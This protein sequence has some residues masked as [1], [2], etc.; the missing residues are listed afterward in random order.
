GSRVSSVDTVIAPQPLGSKSPPD[1]VL[2]AK[3][4][5]GPM[6]WKLNRL[7]DVLQKWDRH[8]GTIAVDAKG[9]L[10]AMTEVYPLGP[11]SILRLD[12]TGGRISEW[13]LKQVNLYSQINDMAVDA[14]G[15]VFLTSAELH[16]IVELDDS[17]NWTRAWSGAGPDHRPIL[18]PVGT[19]VDT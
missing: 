4:I 2:E 12:P 6:L 3:Q 17:G 10:L 15:H 7:G 11:T 5:E 18:Q 19:A 1:T 14:R 13:E 16:K 8:V 9:M